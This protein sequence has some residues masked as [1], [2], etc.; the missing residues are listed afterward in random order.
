VGILGQ[1]EFAETEEKHS[2]QKDLLLK[3]GHIKAMLFQ[4]EGKLF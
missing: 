2:L 3:I 4:E 1:D